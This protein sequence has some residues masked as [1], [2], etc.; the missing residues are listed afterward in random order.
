MKEWGESCV[1]RGASEVDVGGHT[2]TEWNYLKKRY[3]PPPPP[4]T[5]K[6]AILAFVSY[7]GNDTFSGGMHYVVMYLFCHCGSLSFLSF[8]VSIDIT[9]ASVVCFRYAPFFLAA[10]SFL[11]EI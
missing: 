5:K 1:G 6:A 8:H 11:C 2:H 7:T 4:R 3:P 10:T 9:I